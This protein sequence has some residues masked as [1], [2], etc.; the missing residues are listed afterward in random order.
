MCKDILIENYYTYNT[1]GNGIWQI[2]AYAMIQHI[3]PERKMYMYLYA[4]EVF[5]HDLLRIRESTVITALKLTRFKK[6]IAFRVDENAIK[7][8]FFSN[9]E[10]S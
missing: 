7:K 8:F 9:F 4:C 10:E 5:I 1:Y 6:F 3:L 2:Y